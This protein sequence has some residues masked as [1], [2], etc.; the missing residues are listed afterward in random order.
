M[1][2]GVVWVVRLVVSAADGEDV[3][4]VGGRAVVGEQREGRLGRR[5]EG[6]G[7]VLAGVVGGGNLAVEDG[8]GV[9]ARQ[10]RALERPAGGRRW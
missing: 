1:A 7:G 5:R 4:R 6:D 8:L 3:D 2:P 10:P 9:G